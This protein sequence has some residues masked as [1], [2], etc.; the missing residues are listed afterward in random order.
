MMTSTGW[1]EQLPAPAPAPLRCSACHYELRPVDKKCG[2]CW[3]PA[4]GAIDQRIVDEPTWRG[5][6]SGYFDQ[7]L[8][9][10]FTPVNLRVPS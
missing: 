6:R 2:W 3:H 8:A 4:K 7:E 5:G 10:S 1:E 9:E